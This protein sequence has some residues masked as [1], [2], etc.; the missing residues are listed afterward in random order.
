M[1]TLF[2]SSVRSCCSHK[3]A[4]KYLFKIQY[5]YDLM[6]TQIKKKSKGPGLPVTK[7]MGT[8]PIIVE[9]LYQ[10]Q[11]PTN[12]AVSRATPDSKVCSKCRD[13]D[14]GRFWFI[15]FT[16]GWHVIIAQI[17]KTGGHPGVIIPCGTW[18]GWSG[19]SQPKSRHG[20]H[21]V[22]FYIDYQNILYVFKKSIL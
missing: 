16:L 19:T 4:N 8:P 7:F 5:S 2:S 17:W 12:T 21:G 20:H 11:G 9:A 3:H 13:S 18:T 10:R 14:L 6:L 15:W 1:F 22:P